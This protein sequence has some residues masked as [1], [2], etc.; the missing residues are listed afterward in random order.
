MDIETYARLNGLARG[1]GES[2]AQEIFTQRDKSAK[3]RCYPA[4]HDF[5][6][7]NTSHSP[8]NAL[9]FCRK[10]GEIRELSLAQVEKSSK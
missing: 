9:L 1:I 7:F 2:S 10:C 3:Q 8:S 6:A 5:N 4:E